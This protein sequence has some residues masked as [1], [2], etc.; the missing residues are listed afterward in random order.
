MKHEG[1]DGVEAAA[2]DPLLHGFEVGGDVSFHALNVSRK[3]GRI[4]LGRL[5]HHGPDESPGRDACDLVVVCV[6]GRVGE[7]LLDHAE[8]ECGALA[9]CGQC[10]VGLHVTS[11]N[12]LYIIRIEDVGI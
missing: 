2:G 6:T 4:V 3:G 5:R 7:Q 9:P 12:G 8:H 10:Q 11:P 1:V